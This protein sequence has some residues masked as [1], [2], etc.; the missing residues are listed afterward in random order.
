MTTKMN[1]YE[2]IKSMKDLDNEI[3]RLKVKKHIIKEELG[4]NVSD[5]KASLS[6]INLIKEALGFSG[7]SE[8]KFDLLEDKDN[9]FNNG[10]I[11]TYLKYLAL[12]VS[13]VK[14]GTSIVRKIKRIFR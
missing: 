7:S 3:L 4:N 11:F 9:I 1:K 6:P 13:A 8:Q 2:H 14:G 12:T 5:F 10:K